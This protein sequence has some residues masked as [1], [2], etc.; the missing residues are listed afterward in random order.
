MTL[1]EASERK[2]EMVS[3]TFCALP[4]F[5]RSLSPCLSLPL[6]LPFPLSLCLIRFAFHCKFKS[7]YI[8]FITKLINLIWIKYNKS[9]FIYTLT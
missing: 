4:S 2:R 7:F 9:I 6:S 1:L 8:L 5:P 3:G